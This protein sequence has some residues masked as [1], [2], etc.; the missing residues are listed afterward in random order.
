MLI[1]LN[2]KRG[3]NRNLSLWPQ[4]KVKLKLISTVSNLAFAFVAVV[5][6][7]S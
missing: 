3:L 4:K 7:G 1:V 5:C 6:F 2:S